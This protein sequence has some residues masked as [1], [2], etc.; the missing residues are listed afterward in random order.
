MTTKE[1]MRRVIAD[2]IP[3]VC[4]YVCPSERATGEGPQHSEL[5]KSLRAALHGPADDAAYWLGK[6]D[7]TMD[8]LRRVYTPEQLAELG[9]V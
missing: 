4:S 9:I 3:V 2:A 1:T 5:C 8:T 6:Y 7:G